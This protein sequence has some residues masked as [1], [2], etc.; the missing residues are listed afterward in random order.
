MT[1]EFVVYTAT[2]VWQWGGGPAM[3][4]EH[5]G[6]WQSSCNPSELVW[7]FP[8]S[9]SAQPALQALEHLWTRI[10]QELDIYRD[11]VEAV[12]DDARLLWTEW[13][14]EWL[15]KSGAEVYHELQARI[16]DARPKDHAEMAEVL[17]AAEGLVDVT[18]TSLRT[19]EEWD[20]VLDWARGILPSL[21]RA[22]KRF[23]RLPTV[24]VAMSEAEM[25]QP[26]GPVC[27]T[28]LQAQLSHPAEPTAIWSP[29]EH[30]NLTVCKRCDDVPTSVA[31]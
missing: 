3:A 31:A 28:W 17:R 7:E 21:R 30:T 26:D 22:F 11:H 12:A 20:V 8:P 2:G 25:R 6:E 29:C 19:P 14:E 1:A 18:H 4:L 13:A 10:R 27:A 24:D 9:A 16:R 15:E 5:P 23:G